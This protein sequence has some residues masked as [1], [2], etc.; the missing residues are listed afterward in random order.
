MAYDL[1]RFPLEVIIPVETR[2]ARAFAFDFAT[3][4][5]FALIA[6][7][8]SVTSLAVIAFVLVLQS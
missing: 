5:V 4:L 3:V 6:L 1:L 8:K 7:L 2:K